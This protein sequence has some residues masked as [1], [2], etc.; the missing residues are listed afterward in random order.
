MKLVQYQHTHCPLTVKTV[1]QLAGHVL[2][3]QI[4]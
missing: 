3:P 4:V 1:Q 2:L